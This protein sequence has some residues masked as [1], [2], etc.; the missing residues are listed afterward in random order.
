MPFDLVDTDIERDAF[1]ASFTGRPQLPVSERPE[2]VFPLSLVLRLH[3]VRTQREYTIRGD[4]IFAMDSN[5]QFASVDVRIDDPGRDPITFTKGIF[6]RTAVPFNRIYLT[7]LAQ[8]GKQ[9]TLI[10]G[11]YGSMQVGSMGIAA[12]SGIV[13]DVDALNAEIV[14]GVVPVTL[15]NIPLGSVQK[16]RVFNKGATNLFLAITDVLVS[17]LD[18]TVAQSFPLQ[19]GLQTVEFIQGGFLLRSVS[20]AAGGLA[21]VWVNSV[22]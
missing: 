19:A 2:L 3:E 21:R 13:R 10:I 14:V 1:I 11:V 22:L 7:N 20:D 12:Q 9:I 5:A 16:V 4:Y 17:T 18:A 8:V 6:I 15:A